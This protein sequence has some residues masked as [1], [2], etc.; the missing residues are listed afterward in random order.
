MIEIF[1]L[2]TGSVI[3][4]NNSTLTV[5]TQDPNIAF[6][7]QILAIFYGGMIALIANVLLQSLSFWIQDQ[8]NLKNLRT[9]A[10]LD[11]LAHILTVEK[12][13]HMDTG[14]FHSALARAATY[15]SPT[16]KQLLNQLMIT[17]IRNA[18]IYRTSFPDVKDL[19]FKELN[20]SSK[21][22]WQFW[23]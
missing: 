18:E 2:T 22:W 8:K 21:N 4:L 5:Q 13:N 12:I 19:I 1:C 23:K 17:D 3:F 14:K 9:S 15:G 10:Y 7:N 11:L 20:E 6:T 16:I